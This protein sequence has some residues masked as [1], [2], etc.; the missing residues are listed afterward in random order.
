MSVWLLLSDTQNKH[1]QWRQVAGA[2]CL[3]ELHCSPF[4][5]QS[6]LDTFPQVL[7]PLVIWTQKHGTKRSSLKILMFPFNTC[8]CNVK[9][10]STRFLKSSH[11]VVST[12]K[13]I[14]IWTNL[15][16]CASLGWRRNFPNRGLFLCCE[17]T[18]SVTVSPLRLT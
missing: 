15:W 16:L 8:T 2:N 4:C 12:L 11:T 7:S 10:T 5:Y 6:V 13:K 14:L 18:V 3:E 17:L 1:F 9:S